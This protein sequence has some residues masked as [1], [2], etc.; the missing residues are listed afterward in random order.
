MRLSDSQ[1]IDWLRLAR[2][3]GV[4]PHTFQGL[5]N[6]FGGAAAALEALPMLAKAKGRSVII[7]DRAETER[8]LASA[9]AMG[10]SIIAYGESDYP[11]RLR[12]ID[13]PP[14]LLAVKGR[15]ELLHRPAIGMV[16]SRNASAAGRKIASTF[17]RDLGEAGFVVVSG[18][19]RGIDAEAHRAS[20]ETGTIGVLAGGLDKPYP[21]ENHDLFDALCENGLALTE[22]P[23]GWVPR[24]RDF[25][26]RN[27]L[28]SGLSLGIVV[29]EA[30]RQSGS[31]I[32]ARM[33]GEQGREVFAVPGS[34]LD[35]RCEGT[36][37]LLR[38]G[39]TMAARAGDVLA[40]LRPLAGDLDR[41]P[42]LFRE[43]RQS[44]PDGDEQAGLF[45]ES[46][47]GGAPLPTDPDDLLAGQEA[48][49]AAATSPR[50]RVLNMLGVTPV[51]ADHVQRSSGLAARDFAA[52]L[53]DLELAGEVERHSGN[54]ISRKTG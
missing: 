4:G 12:E 31:L 47:S 1:R 7:P 32:T 6:R 20:L 34:P 54:R 18:F 8:E 38:T 39:A 16:G 22:M 27:R 21:P 15:I 43:T 29:V 11:G 50:D 26:R 52:L 42:L 36:N 35:P 30:A 24:G 9:D 40:V 17:A 33:A 10:A 37:D 23:F 46:F 3:Q 48:E 44:R 5:I 13:G 28:I 19:A 53:F 45:D 14:P 2:V 51:D 41:A 49:V 25:P